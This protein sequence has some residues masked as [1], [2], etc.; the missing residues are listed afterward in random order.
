M[1]RL[2]QLADRH[3]ALDDFVARC[4]SVAGCVLD[5]DPRRLT[6]CVR[7]LSFTDRPPLST[8]ERVVVR[9]LAGQ[10]L[11]R[12][13][14]MAGVDRRADVMAAFLE[15]ERCDLASGRFFDDVNRLVAACAAAVETARV[16]RQMPAEP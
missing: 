3:P 6:T 10:T 7:R 9:Q 15:W 1:V 14:T 12:A 4:Q 16:D 11:A 13:V 5:G 2:P 8:I